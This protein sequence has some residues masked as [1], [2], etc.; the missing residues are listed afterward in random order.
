MLKYFF[1]W[2][3]AKYGPEA[4]S[5]PFFPASA[6]AGHRESFG[7]ALGAAARRLGLPHVTPHGL[8]SYFATK[9]LRDGLRSEE[10]ASL[11]GDQTVKLITSTYTDNV[12]GEKLYWKPKNGVPAWTYFGLKSLQSVE[13]AI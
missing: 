7:V 13:N 4:K 11:M 9:H 3:D 2:H 1:Q 6:G 8:R 5:L 10:I 12:K